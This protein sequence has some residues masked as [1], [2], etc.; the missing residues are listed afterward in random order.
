MSPKQADT[1]S[2][3]RIWKNVFHGRDPPPAPVWPH[4]SSVQTCRWRGPGASSRVN[5]RKHSYLHQAGDS[6]FQRSVGTLLEKVGKGHTEG[7]A[8][9]LSL[10]GPNRCLPGREAGREQPPGRGK[11]MC[12]SL[13]SGN[14][15]QSAWQ[16][17]PGQWEAR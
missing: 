14:E 15:E 12:G 9:P 6:C 16:V 17:L 13:E 11:S 3:C 5:R 2:V 1:D 10:Q 4:P 7:L 8:L